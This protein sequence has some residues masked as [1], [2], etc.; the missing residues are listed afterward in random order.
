MRVC[1]DEIAG[2]ADVR[3]LARRRLWARLAIVL[4]LVV[5]GVQWVRIALEPRGDFK[6]HWELGRRLLA[7]EFIYAGGHDR[8]YPPFWGLA[9][10]PLTVLPMPLAQVLLFP[11]CIVSLWL[12][13]RVLGRLTER[14]LPLGREAQF[15]AAAAAVLLASRF[16]IRDMVECGVNLALV[17]L[18]WW[19]VWCWT[20]RRDVWGGT[21][22]GLAISLK[23]TPALF[24]AYFVWKRQWKIAAATIVAAVGIS[25]SP[26]LWMGPAAF[27]DAGRYWLSQV[28]LSVGSRDPL[29]GVLGPEPLQ[30]V[31]LRPALAR[32][33][34]FPE[35]GHPGR[36]DHP[37]SLQFLN[38]PP[39]MADGLVKACLAVLLVAAALCCRGTANRDEPSAV[40]RESAAVSLLILLFSPITWGQHCVGALPALILLVRE[41]FHR[42]GLPA[43]TW[44]VLAIYAAA[45]LGL[46]RTLIGQRASWLLDSYHVTTWCLVLLLSVTL[47]RCRS[48]QTA[49]AAAAPLTKRAGA[50]LADASGGRAA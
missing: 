2:P 12:L 42:R 45:I 10:A 7:G 15:W 33:L 23:C 40:V 16:L 41:G 8:P 35:P 27:A 17:T 49:R 32:F 37:W 34:V 11:L 28:W 13:L 18:S 5:V 14:Q 31:S 38:L 50:P 29:Q 25:L 47:R 48:E 24:W 39:T 26:V 43:G 1:S 3:R 30:N 6:L 4:G 46:N 44:V 22:L 9:H 19:A 20:Q 36:F 21:L